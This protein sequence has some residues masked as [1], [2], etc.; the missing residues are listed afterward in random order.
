MKPT[1]FSKQKVKSIHQISLSLGIIVALSFLLV[2]FEWNSNY[3]KLKTYTQNGALIEVVEIDVTV[4]TP[5]PPKP[6]IEEI[7]VASPEEII[8]KDEE[9]ASVKLISTEDIPTVSEVVKNTAPELPARREEADETILDFAD[10]APF[11]TG[12]ESALMA[13]LSQSIKYPVVDIEQGNQGR[14]ICTFVVE[15]DGSITDINVV[16]SVSP[17]IDKEAIRVI[18]AMPNWN[19]GVKDGKLVRVK[20]TLPIHF[21]LE[22]TY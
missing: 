17:T 12:G 5:D 9:V 1:E 15:K 14:V 3:A 10:I 22:R 4:R 8:V 11:F 6:K 19:P 13:F 18:S 7:Q 2:A 16:R 21:K 20:F